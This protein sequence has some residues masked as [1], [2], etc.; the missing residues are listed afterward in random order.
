[1]N[2]AIVIG[3]SVYLDASN[4][5]PGCK[6][7]AQ[8]IYQVLKLS[9]K[10]ENILYLNDDENSLK[11]K[12]EIS[13][14]ITKNKGGAVDEFFFYY[15]GHGEFFNEEFYYILSDFNTKKRNQSSLQNTELDNLIRSVSPEL[16]I[17]VIDACQSGTTYIKDIN[18]VSKFFDESKKIFKKCYFL[19]SSLTSQSSYQ[20]INY[21]AFTFSFINA[22]KNHTG[23]EIR[24]KD[25]IDVISDDF[26]DNKEQTPFYIVQ[27]EFTEKFCSLTDSLKN[28]INAVKSSELEEKKYTLSIAD[29][30]KKDAEEYVN[31]EG[32][33]NAILEMQKAFQNIKFNAEF[34]EL[35]SY[36]ADF[37]TDYKK[38]PKTEALDKWFRENKGEYFYGAIYEEDVQEDEFGNQYLEDVLTGFDLSI[39]APFNTISIEIS[40]KYPNIYNYNCTVLYFISKKNIRFLYFV[41]NYLYKGWEKL[42]M[43]LKGIQWIVQENK[44]NDTSDIILGVNSICKDIEKKINEDLANSLSLSTNS[45]INDSEVS[46]PALLK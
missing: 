39:D 13:N 7:D 12:E 42:S 6:N 32:A 23:E 20:D 15:S 4:N 3:V 45:S 22:L 26:A 36:S 18:I 21:S 8:A 25:I 2:L 17:K 35:F 34:E 40:A 10:F 9:N 27:A 1:M 30:V 5:L 38:V 16:L 37:L 44:I 28:Y 29:L 33:L 41:T 11:I 31:E 24:Y 46:W 43:N 14:F 19:N